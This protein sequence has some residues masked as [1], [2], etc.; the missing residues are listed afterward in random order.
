MFRVSATIKTTM[1]ATSEHQL[2]PLENWRLE[3]SNP[4]PTQTTTTGRLNQQQEWE[5][6]KGN[7]LLPPLRCWI[8]YGKRIQCNSTLGYVVS[9]KALWKLQISVYYIMLLGPL[10]YRLR[11]NS[12][13]SPRVHSTV[14]CRE[15]Q[16]S[17]GHNCTIH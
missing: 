9:M 8:Y 5:A 12:V 6:S 11:T 17:K 15:F 4:P 1:R 3:G 14:N 10:S 2:T 13:L 7:H 16:L